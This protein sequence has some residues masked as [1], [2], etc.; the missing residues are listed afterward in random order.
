[1]VMPIDVPKVAIDGFAQLMKDHEELSDHILKNNGID[2]SLEG[3]R[4]MARMNVCGPNDMPSGW[5]LKFTRALEDEVRELKESIA[6]KWWKP[7]VKT[8][9]ENVRVELIDIFHF[10][11]SAAACAG[12]TADDFVT[13]YYQKR[14]LNF[15]R[16]RVGF[17]DGDNKERKIGSLQE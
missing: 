9:L 1:M 5:L 10:V 3:L 8:D 12:M 4:T 14:Q 7:Q 15:D 11:L 13:T 16:Q 6:W 2:V 17:K